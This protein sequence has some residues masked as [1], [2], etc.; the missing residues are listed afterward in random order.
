MENLQ[1][2]EELRLYQ[3]QLARSNAL[4]QEG[5]EEKKREREEQMTTQQDDDVQCDII[6][7]SDL[8][9]LQFRLS[10]LTE[11]LYQE[12]QAS[13]ALEARLQQALDEA[14]RLKDE[15]ERL[16]DATSHAL[17]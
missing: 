17:F 1:L 2:Q 13:H 6:T 9:T 14:G 10:Q 4:I 3:E 16:Q 11:Q 8:S 15:A 5:L 12:Q 7:E